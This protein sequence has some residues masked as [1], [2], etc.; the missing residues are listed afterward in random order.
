MSAL[1]LLR[2]K[3]LKPEH[4]ETGGN[5]RMTRRERVAFAAST[6][7]AAGLS[8]AQYNL[9]H[10]IICR[11][12]SNCC[13]GARR[14]MTSRSFARGGGRGERVLA[15]R[16]ACHRAI[17]HH[18]VMPRNAPISCASRPG[19]TARWRRRSENSESYDRVA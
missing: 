9:K 15:A 14:R 1:L 11:E 13:A 2:L 17:R 12:E 10:Q 19:D 8:G 7:K 4:R 18:Q 6:S 3:M 5:G 16:R